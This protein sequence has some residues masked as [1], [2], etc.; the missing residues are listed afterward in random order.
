MIQAD[1]GCIIDVLLNSWDVL[2]ADLGC[3]IDVLP[4]SWDVCRLI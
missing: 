3:I 4:N 2:Q 1:L